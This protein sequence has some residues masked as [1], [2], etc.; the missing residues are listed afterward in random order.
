V[1]SYPA[2]GRQL[3]GCLVSLLV[4]PCCDYLPEEIQ[5]LLN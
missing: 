2:A 4:A 5:D 3:M 1:G